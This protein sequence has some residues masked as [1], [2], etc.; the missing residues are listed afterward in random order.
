VCVT[1]DV[2]AINA[3]MGL[4]CA[5]ARHGRIS[6]CLCRNLGTGDGDWVNG[7]S[8]Y[9]MHGMVGDKGGRRVI[10]LTLIRRMGLDESTKKK[11][12]GLSIKDGRVSYFRSCLQKELDAKTLVKRLS[13][14][15]LW[16]CGWML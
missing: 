6:W 5:D 14:L 9:D 8:A 11:R 13:Q 1:R 12:M 10:Y 3:P 16:F 7:M 2:S 4:G 15:S